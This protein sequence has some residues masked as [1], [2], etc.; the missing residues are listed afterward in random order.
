MMIRF[1]WARPFSGQRKSGHSYRP[2]FLRLDS[3]GYRSSPDGSLKDLKDIVAVVSVGSRSDGI[4]NRL[5][6]LR[7]LPADST[8]STYRVGLPLGQSFGLPHTSIPPPPLEASSTVSLDYKATFGRYVRAPRI[9]RPS[10]PLR[11][12]VC[13]RPAI[14]LPNRALVLLAAIFQSNAEAT[15]TA[16]G[17]PSNALNL[18]SIARQRT[19]AIGY[20]AAE[21][22][23][24]PRKNPCLRLSPKCGRDPRQIVGEVRASTYREVDATSSSIN[25]PSRV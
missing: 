7:N 18:P 4:T 14:L 3:R 10:I 13:I 20:L 22:V 1:T 2:Q 5:H 15:A 11:A 6:D 25:I 24:T 9:L 17:L 16:R 19:V 23:P 21:V 8:A 12:T